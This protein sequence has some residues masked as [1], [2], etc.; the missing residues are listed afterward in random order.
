MDLKIFRHKSPAGFA[1]LQDLND[2]ERF[3]EKPSDFY[4][5]VRIRG[6]L[7]YKKVI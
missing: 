1:F 5:K 2:G 6:T 4:A 3:E 7:A